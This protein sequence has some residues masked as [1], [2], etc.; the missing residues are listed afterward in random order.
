ML[1][2]VRRQTF[3]LCTQKQRTRTH[4]RHARISRSIEFS[5]PV[6]TQSRVIRV[7]CKARVNYPRVKIA[8]M[9]MWISSCARVLPCGNGTCGARWRCVASRAAGGE[10]RGFVLGGRQWVGMLAGVCGALWRRHV[11]VALVTLCRFV[12]CSDCVV[13]VCF[14][15]TGSFHGAHLRLDVTGESAYNVFA[16]WDGLPPHRLWQQ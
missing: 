13:C 8:R 6:W 11:H 14:E 10:V 7:L 2:T 9:C 16:T 15:Q 5:T 3:P 1:Y 4:T 12:E